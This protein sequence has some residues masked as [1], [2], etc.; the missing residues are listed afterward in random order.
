[1]LQGYSS[2][3]IKCDGAR[4]LPRQLDIPPSVRRKR[5]LV[6]ILG[7]LARQFQR[8]VHRIRKVL[9]QRGEQERPVVFDPKVAFAR[10]DVLG[11]PLVAFFEDVRLLEVFLCEPVLVPSA[12]R[13]VSLNPVALDAKE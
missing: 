8:A 9:P 5:A 6:H 7:R 13:G 11:E 10:V 12:D 3:I 1:M 2:L 4:L